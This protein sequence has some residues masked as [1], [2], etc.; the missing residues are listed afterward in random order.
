[1]AEVAKRQITDVSEAAMKEKEAAVS[2][3][4]QS[5]QRRA[6]KEALQQ[7]ML[8]LMHF[9]FR[10]SLCDTNLVFILSAAAAWNMC[11]V[12]WAT[13]AMLS[14]PVTSAYV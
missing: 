11:I 9:H 2:K 6:S 10:C 4:M 12:V 5:V 1:M 8:C 13:W 7:V 14:L 3:C